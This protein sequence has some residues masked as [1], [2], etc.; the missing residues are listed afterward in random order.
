[1]PPGYVF[2]LGTVPQYD[3]YTQL[4]WIAEN[5]WD[6]QTK[7]P[8]KIGGAAW[9]EDFSNAQF[10]AMK[11]YASVHPD[12]FKWENGFLTDFK[13]NWTA[14]VESLKDC[15]YVYPPVP[16]H[17]FA[18]EFRRNGYDAKFIG[19][20]PHAG[21]LDIIDQ[22]DYWDEI[23]GM[24]FIRGSRWWTEE[25]FLIDLTK[26]ILFDNHSNEAEEIMR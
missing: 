5:D 19:N 2:S 8:A 17:V 3:S 15:D 16:M 22:G 14:E 7:G 13:F 25:G 20:D 4:K 24:L 21:F 9:S 23:D 1:M 11:E 6:W 18:N 26:Q 12:Q 10:S